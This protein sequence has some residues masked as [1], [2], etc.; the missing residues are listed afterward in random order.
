MNTRLTVSV[1]HPLVWA[2]IA[3]APR[4]SAQTVGQLIPHKVKL[5][6]VDYQGKRQSRSPKRARWPM[7]KPMR[8]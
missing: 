1:C 8:S 3:V 6:A 7:V 4:A 5:E 2:L